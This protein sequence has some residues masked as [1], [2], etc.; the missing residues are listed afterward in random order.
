[1]YGPTNVK[2]IQQHPVCSYVM[3]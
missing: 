2:F 3:T 1:M